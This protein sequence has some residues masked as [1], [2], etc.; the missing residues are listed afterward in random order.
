MSKSLN[1]FAP[2]LGGAA[3]TLGIA[4]GVASRDYGAQ[5][6]ES[7]ETRVAQSEESA[8][9]ALAKA[10][11]SAATAM[12]LAAE[13][14]ALQEVAASGGGLTAPAPMHEDEYGLG[15]TAL[16]DEIA[17]WDIDVLPDGRGLP[18]GRGDVYTGEEVFVDRC[19]SCH[20]DFA[21]GVG[22]WPVLAGGF[23]TLADEDPVKTV[24]SY[25][26]HLSTA[27][28]Y[29]NRSMPF[30]EAGTL[31]ADD[32]YAIV[33]Y[34][35]YS[36]DMVDDDF[37]LSHENFAEVEMHNADG[38][39][40]DDRAELEYAEWRAEPCMSNCKDSVEITMRATFLDVT[41]EGGGESVMN[42]ASADDAPVFTATA[43]AESTSPDPAL[44]AE[45]E[46]AFRQCKSCHQIGAGAKDRTGPQLNNII[47]RTV[48]GIDGFRYSR[49]FAEAADAGQVWDADSL[50]AFLTDPRGAMSGTKM[51]F[52][53]VS[54]PA[55]V[56]ALIAY[57]EAAGA[58]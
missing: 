56:A 46:G 13:R 44:I 52:R 51:A 42:H 19:A 40:V 28:D 49:V 20:G 33:A 38:F 18:E 24:G 9:Q 7:L 34:I 58:E 35:L 47:G 54:D 11:T 43:G 27:W 57:L 5:T 45:G 25:W 8:A 14:D 36:N 16:S 29:I 30:G 37:E 17:A 41:P 55:E 12:E 50:A 6:I 21:E 4:Y 53:G 39:V 22:N 23:D 10:E 48:G 31:T 3:L 32:T 15:R 26:P 2:A 1:L